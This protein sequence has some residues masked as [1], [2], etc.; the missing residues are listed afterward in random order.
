M[1]SCGQAAPGKRHPQQ[2]SSPCPRRRAHLPQ[3]RGAQRRARLLPV[4]PRR[5]GGMRSGTRGITNLTLLPTCQY[6]GTLRRLNASRKTTMGYISEK[7]LV[8]PQPR[9]QK[10][11]QPDASRD[12]ALHGV[13]AR[14]PEARICEGLAACNPERNPIPTKPRAGEELRHAT[15][16]FEQDTQSRT[17]IHRQ[18]L[19]QG[20]DSHNHV[21]FNFHVDLN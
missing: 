11:D 18:Q 4:S 2:L 6:P 15:A 19:L 20:P 13:S 16:S 14:A 10:N 8:R 21:V 9:Q 7:P 5:F 3:P 17:R 12:K 1:R